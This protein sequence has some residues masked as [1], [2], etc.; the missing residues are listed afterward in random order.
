M[1][2]AGLF[3]LHEGVGSTIFTSQV[4]EH[5]LNMNRRGIRLEILTFETFRKAR[6]ISEKNLQFIAEKYKS[7]KV[8]LK[9]GMNIY[10]PFSTVINAIT[11]AR[12]LVRHRTEYSFIH[13]RADYTAFLC[14]LTKPLHGLPVLWDCRGDAVGEL[15]DSLSRHSRFLRVTLGIVLLMRQK[16]IAAFSGHF[17][18]GAIFV[19]NELFKQ[20]STT[21]CTKNHVVIPCP[22]PEDQF[23]FDE[24]LRKRMRIQ[25]GI[26]EEQRVFLY[27][28]SMVAYQGLTEQVD[29][30][31]KLLVTPENIIV[32]ATP[33]PDYAR[34]YFHALPMDQFHIVSVEYSEM[35]DICNLADFAFMLRAP[36]NFNWVA[37]PT[38]FGE[39][40]LTG[41]AVILNETIQQS[42]ENAKALGN[43]V[44]INNIFSELPLKND[45]RRAVAEKARKIYS[46]GALS[47][48]YADLYATICW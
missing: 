46:R 30:Y 4:L 2:K 1:S 25:Y 9:T 43:Y 19:S 33:E 44:H 11:L 6:K 10:F 22:V 21:L 31:K 37:S 26:S 13:A 17:A 42:S 48:T 18:D 8:D 27:S 20:H 32:F 5:V 45:V 24:T 39:Y 16:I 34:E 15:Q 35:N 47:L 40:C 41:L 28:G 29:L 23:Y 14:L 38:K 3:V 12:Y 7:V 36:K